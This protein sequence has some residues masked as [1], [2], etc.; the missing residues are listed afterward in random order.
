MSQA[1]KQKQKE[2]D[3]VKQV[4][5]RLDSCLGCSSTLKMEAKCAT[6]TSVGFQLITRHYVPEDT[7]LHLDVLFPAF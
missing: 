7:A 4:A 3:S 1:K 2:K 5:S 6:R